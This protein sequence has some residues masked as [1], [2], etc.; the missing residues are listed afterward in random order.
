MIY[1]SWSMKKM[2]DKLHGL[3]R[4]PL[5]LG[6]GCGEGIAEQRKNSSPYFL[7][8]R[9]REKRIKKWLA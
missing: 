9:R 5:P 3:L 2:S 8:L 1:G 4:L 6:E 7:A